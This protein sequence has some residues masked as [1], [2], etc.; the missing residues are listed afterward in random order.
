MNILWLSVNDGLYSPKGSSGYHGG[1]WVS[2]L[3]NLIIQQ[4]QCHLGL[5]FITHE[6]LTEIQMGNT[7][8]FPI[9]QPKVS[10]LKK[11]QH[12]YGGYKNADKDLYIDRINDVVTR[13]QPD[14]IHLFGVENP[15]ATILG[16]TNIPVVVHLQGLLS[17]C[18]NAFFP[19]GFNK[20]SFF[21]P[22]SMREWVLR[23]GYIFA[24]KSIHIRGQREE[25]L[26][27]HIMYCMGRTDWDYMVSHL[28]AP[29]SIYYHVDEVLRP[30]F[31]EHAGQWQLIAKDGRFVIIST[32]SN[33]VYKGLDMVLKTAA[34]LK[35]HSEICFEWR[36][37]GISHRSE[38]VSF[39]ERTLNILSSEVGVKYMGVKN[40]TELCTLLLESD[41]YM[42]PS[43]I[44]NSPNSLCEAMLLGMPVLA[45]Y[46][47][48]VPSLLQRGQCGIL[49]PANGPYELAHELMRLQRNP[50]IAVELGRAAFECAESRHK[51]DVIVQQLLSTYKEVIK[52]HQNCNTL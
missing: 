11:I 42:H 9:Y 3:Q 28:L 19:P 47:G 27:K 39:F 52:N 45:A 4:P 26:F 1:G 44:D 38:V 41:C 49:V 48:G 10:M 36:V 23:N 15:M 29:R 5:V 25:A 20:S 46:V 34:L 18:D 6:R 33:T 21:F 43:Y 50:D 2:S 22:F 32:L 40:E 7:M 8:Y 51:Q 37:V 24:K 35:K 13:F 30:P 12:Y 14:I 17:P 16:K 31:Y